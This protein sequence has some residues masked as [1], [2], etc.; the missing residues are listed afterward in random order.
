[1]NI[2]S[3]IRLTSSFAGLLALLFIFACGGGDT[4]TVNTATI[5][6]EDPLMIL[7]NGNNSSITNLL[8]VIKD[9]L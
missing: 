9:H 6:V 2:G 8:L 5:S 3:C 7:A 4:T 1:M